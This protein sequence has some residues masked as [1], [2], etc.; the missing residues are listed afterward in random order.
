MSVG[1]VGPEPP[2]RFHQTGSLQ[3]ALS[4]LSRETYFRGRK[5][6][7]LQQKT[8]HVDEKGCTGADVTRMS[9]L[10]V[11]VCRST[12]LPEGGAVLQLMGERCWTLCVCLEREQDTH[13]QPARSRALR[14]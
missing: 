5:Q 13:T 10:C 6:S 14:M 12:G 1:T 8:G 9:I 2:E 3:A 11:C 4:Q 7:L